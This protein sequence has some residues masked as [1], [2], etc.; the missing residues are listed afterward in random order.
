ML[1]S[2]VVLQ[3]ADPLLLL[4]LAEHIQALHFDTAEFHPTT[5]ESM[6]G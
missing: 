1:R 6:Q 5:W 4:Q 3:L 2:L